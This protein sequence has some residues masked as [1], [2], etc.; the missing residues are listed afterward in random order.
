MKYDH[1][2]TQDGQIYKSGEDVPDLG[3][4]TC[5]QA[6]GNVRNYVFASKDL[7]KLPT[8]DD[9][10][11]GSAALAADTSMVY[12]YESSSKTWYPQGE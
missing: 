5:I 7:N 10:S 9:L 3:S 12:V 4:I 8:Y 6:K 1:T 11:S 2:V